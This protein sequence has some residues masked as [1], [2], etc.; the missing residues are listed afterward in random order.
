MKGLNT[1]SYAPYRPFLTEVGDI[2][3]CRVVPYEN[4]IHFEW[5]DINAK[6]Y[7]FFSKNAPM[8]SFYLPEKPTGVSLILKSLQ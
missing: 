2:Y 3:I 8:K 4:K 1:W 7:N 6:E 5:L